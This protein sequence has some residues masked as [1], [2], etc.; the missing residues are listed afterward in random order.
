MEEVAGPVE[1][2]GELN[3]INIIKERDSQTFAENSVSLMN[4]LGINHLYDLQ[5]IC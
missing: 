1:E 4:A 3:S 2:V 5:G